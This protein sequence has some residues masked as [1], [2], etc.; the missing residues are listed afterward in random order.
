[1]LHLSYET[2]TE[3]VSRI[4]ENIELLLIDHAHCEKKAAS[5][6]LNL[7]FRYPNIPSIVEAMSPIAR[8][9]LEHFELMLSVIAEK[10]FQFRKLSP[11][12]YAGRLLSKVRT[13]EIPKL[14]DTLICCALIE[15][16]S[17]ERMTL[18]SEHLAC[19][20]LRGVYRNLLESEARH[21]STYLSIARSIVSKSE[22]FERLETLSIWEAEVISS[23][24]L[25][26]RMHN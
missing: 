21:F 18:L 20:Y 22:V 16:R 26:P 5:T 19:E 8:E 10:G 6:A 13:S 2:P 24:P 17:C 7:I 14:V 11:S 3:W 4:E 15:A 1:M 9:E 23:A 25:V 12:P